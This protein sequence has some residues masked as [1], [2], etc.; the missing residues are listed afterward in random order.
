MLLDCVCPLED[1]E[2]E[3]ER[4]REEER[5]TEEERPSKVQSWYCQESSERY[6][7]REGGREGRE[8]RGVRGGRGGRGKRQFIR[9][10]LG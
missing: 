10:G 4:E 9:R 5:H 8:G 3:K 2:R 7:R 6:V 1:T